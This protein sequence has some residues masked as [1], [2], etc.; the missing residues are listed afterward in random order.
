MRGH[1]TEC[2]HFALRRVTGHRLL[3]PGRRRYSA[4]RGPCSSKNMDTNERTGLRQPFRT[5]EG[6]FLREAS[7]MVEA[8]RQKLL[9]EYASA[10]RAFAD[11]V[12]R[13]PRADHEVE[14]FIRALDEVGAA[15]RV[16]E[17]ARIKLGKYLAQR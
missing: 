4:W 15:H 9:C 8:V 12:G 11:A 6:Q 1:V 3:V 17:Q 14:A 13:L 2:G 5:P 7:K 16:C 10:S